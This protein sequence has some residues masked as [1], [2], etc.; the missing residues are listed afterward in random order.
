MENSIQVFNNA[1]FG[2][3]RTI[4][5]N[6]KTM[7]C[8]KD[9]AI[10]LG[11]SIPSKAINTHCKGVS[12]M[13]VPTSGGNQKLIFISEGDVYRL[14]AKSKLSAAEKFESW[15]FDDVLP[16][17]RKSGSYSIATE[18]YLIED[19]IKR[20]ERWIEEQKQRLALET[21]VEQQKPM[22]DIAEQR[23][24]K[25]GC[26]SIT[27]VTRSL[28]LKTGQITNWAKN[29]GYIHKSRH[30]VNEKGLP[31]FK[32]YSE[33]KVHNSIGITEV[34]IEHIRVNLEEIKDTPCKTSKNK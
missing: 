11:Y 7:F 4:E 24:D 19:P 31:F 21:K 12:K 20:A 32:V 2:Q 28:K 8:G 1:D 29:K 25:K 9:V 23:I 22:V 18:S 15:V 16:S 13:E 26:M 33:D 34:G 14:I 3:M 6:G 27:D 17:I 30:E 5:V 10:A